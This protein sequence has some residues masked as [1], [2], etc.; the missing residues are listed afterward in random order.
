[1][2]FLVQLKDTPVLWPIYMAAIGWA[3]FAFVSQSWP[4]SWWLDVRSVQVNDSKVG[5][6]VTMKVDRTIKRNFQ[7]VWNV[8]VRKVEDG[9]DSVFCTASSMSEY[10][11]GAELPKSLTLDWWADGRC[12]ALPAGQ[13]F[14]STAWRIESNGMLPSKRVQIDSNIFEVLP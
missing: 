12:D 11:P 3:A 9:S 10:R 5:H 7:A 14:V 6:K 13:Y 8:S 1:M 2:K 4:A